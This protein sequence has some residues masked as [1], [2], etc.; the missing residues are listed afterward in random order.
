MATFSNTYWLSTPFL[1]LLWEIFPTPAVT[2]LTPFS[3]FFLCLRMKPIHIGVTTDLRS[4]F[5]TVIKFKSN[6]C[7]FPTWIILQREYIALAIT[8]WK[9]K[10]LIQLLKSM[11]NSTLSHC[12]YAL[13]QSGVCSSCQKS[14]IEP[15]IIFHLTMSEVQ[16]ENMSFSFEI[17]V[18]YIF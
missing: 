9:F 7:D 1:Q 18:I 14:C 2:I 3:Y 13:W 17:I 8:A 15:N 10:F 6:F 5:L 11:T 16:K 4:R 12:H